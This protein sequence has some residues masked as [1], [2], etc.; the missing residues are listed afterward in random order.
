[1]LDRK[2]VTGHRLH[3]TT[4]LASISRRYSTEVS[5]KNSTMAINPS[6]NDSTVVTQISPIKLGRIRS[7]RL[8][9]SRSATQRVKTCWNRP[10]RV[11]ETAIR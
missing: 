10:D 11:R 1:M 8:A 3:S 4:K 7:L 9:Y 5:L 6:P 2:I